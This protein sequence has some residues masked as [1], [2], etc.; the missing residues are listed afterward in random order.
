MPLS[1]WERKAKLGYG[2]VRAVAKRTARSESHVSQV[3]RCEQTARRDGKVERV[4]AKLIGLPV[5]AV[6]PPAPPKPAHRRV[7]RTAA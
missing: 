4:V 1:M 3:L 2:G 7:R 5:E 6:F